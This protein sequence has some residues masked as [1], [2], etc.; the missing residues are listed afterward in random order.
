MPTYIFQTK[1]R[2]LIFE[3]QIS[4]LIDIDSIDN[5]KKKKKAFDQNADADDLL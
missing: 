1:M 5:K 3:N 2:Y 4:S